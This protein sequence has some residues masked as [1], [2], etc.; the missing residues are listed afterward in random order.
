M[1]EDTLMHMDKVE[2]HAFAFGGRAVGRRADGKI[3]FV[4]GAIPGETVLVRITGEKKRYS[5]GVLSEILT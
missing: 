4:R 3:C 2:I 1:Q 5:E